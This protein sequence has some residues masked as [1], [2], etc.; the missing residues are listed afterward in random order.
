M[1]WWH[2][3][4]IDPLDLYFHF[5][6]L[7]DFTKDLPLGTARWE[8]L[9]TAPP[10]F[11]DKS[12]QPET[13]DA[14]VIPAEPLGQAGAR[15]VRRPQRRHDRRMTACRCNS[16]TATGTRDLQESAHVRGRLIRGPASSSSASAR[17]PIPA[18]SASG[19]TT[20]CSSS[21]LPCGEELGKKS[22]YRPQWKLWETTYDEDVAVDVPAGAHRIR[23]RELRQRLG[24]RSPSTPSPAARV[25]DR[26][27]VLV[28]GMRSPQVAMLWLQNRE[29]GW[30]NHGQGQVAQVE[31]FTVAVHG[32]RDGRYQVQWWDTWNGKVERSEAVEVRNGLVRLTVGPLKTDVAAKLRPEN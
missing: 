17:S 28:C 27:N 5:T 9:E 8:P 6:A 15:R 11:V 13:R 22:V 25:L 12:R 21:A 31:P 30:Y 1:P 18:C 19:S 24:Q 3:N 10:E 16:S 23:V 14:V 26:P 32:L 4:Y 29:S 20:S 2:E 7:A